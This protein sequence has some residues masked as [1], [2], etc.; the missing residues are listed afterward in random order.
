MANI[1]EKANSILAGNL[2]SGLS[3]LNTTVCDT[4]NTDAWACVCA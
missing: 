4:Y 3:Y 1:W 2:K